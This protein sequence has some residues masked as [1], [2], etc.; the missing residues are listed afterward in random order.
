VDIDTSGCGFAVAPLYFTGLAG[1]SRHVFTTGATSVYNRTAT[2]LRVF[3]R[4]ADGSP[5]TAAEANS[6]EW[7]IAWAAIRDQTQSATLCAGKTGDT[8]WVSYNDGIYLDANTSACGLSTTPHCQTTLGG[9]RHWV[10]T[11]D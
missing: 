9:T 7:H 5:L 4:W 11:G 3:V 1:R 6:W 2:G 10:T 8:G